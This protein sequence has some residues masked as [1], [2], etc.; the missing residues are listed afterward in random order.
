MNKF[1]KFS[2][3][4]WRNDKHFILGNNI[5]Q[6][7]NRYL[8]LNALNFND[9]ILYWYNSIEDSRLTFNLRRERIKSAFSIAKTP[10]SD[11]YLRLN[12]KAHIRQITLREYILLSE[13]LKRFKLQFNKKKHKLIEYEKT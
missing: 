9:D 6:Y 5:G 4:E 10:T 7:H 1:P 12:S 2:I 8:C 3:I 13:H 11:Y